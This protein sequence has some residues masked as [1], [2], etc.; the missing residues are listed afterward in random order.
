MRNQFNRKLKPPG[1]GLFSKG[2]SFSKENLTSRYIQVAEG[3]DLTD[4]YGV[5]VDIPYVSG[6]GKDQ[7]F[8]FGVLND[9]RFDKGCY[10]GNLYGL[11]EYY[12]SPY[13]NIY[14]DDSTAITR[15]YWKLPDFHYANLLAQG[16]TLQN[17]FFLKAKATTKTS[18]EILSM[19]ELLVYSVEQMNENL[20]RI[21]TWIGTHD[22]YSE[23]LVLN[24]TFDNSDNWTM[25][26]GWSISSGKLNGN[27]DTGFIRTTQNI[28]LQSG[29][30]YKISYEIS[31]M[32][33]GG[34]RAYF[35]TDSFGM[36]R[37]TNGKYE[38]LVNMNTHYSVLYLYTYVGFKGSID[39]LILQSFHQNYYKS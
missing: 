22:F 16:N 13:V 21:K 15:C 10:V 2:S 37:F 33:F 29:L 25:S 8:D 30:T 7:I 14:Y 5:E 19:Q 1:V 35:S 34:F 23:N 11:A 3:D 12:D 18:N 9:L 27:I 24:G 36:T 31:N 26:S 4:I 6:V 39:N 28:F 17:V 20:S 32:T 38:E